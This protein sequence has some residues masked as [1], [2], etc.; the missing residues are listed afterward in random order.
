MKIINLDLDNTLIYS[1][2]HDIGSHKRNVEIYEGREVSYITERTFHSLQEVRKSYLVVPTS[3]RTVEQYNRIKLGVGKFPYALVCNGGI[4]LRNGEVDKAWYEES[5][6]IIQDSQDSMHRARIYLEKEQRRY[7]EIRYIEKL[8]VFT[9]C[10]EPEQ[11]VT[12]LRGKLDLHVVDIFNNGEKVY[13]VPCNLSKGV[14]IERLKKMLHPELVIAAGDSEFDIS[15]VEAADKGLVPYGFKEKFGVT[16]GVYEM[17]QHRVFAEALL[18]ECISNS[19]ES[20]VKVARRDNNNK[21]L[22]LVVNPLQ[23]KHI[24]V[25]PSQALSVFNQLVKQL[26]DV[27]RG[28]NVLVIG[29]AETATAIGAQVAISLGTNYIHTTR[30]TIPDV[31]Y[32][33]FSEEHSHATEQ[34]LVKNDMDRIIKNIDRILFIEDEVTTGNTILNII[35]VLENQYGQITK[36]SVASLLNGMSEEALERYREANIL[37]HYLVKTDHSTF[38]KLVDSYVCDGK[39]IDVDQTS[40]DIDVVQI[41]GC[42]NTRRLVDS[43]Q[44]LRACKGLAKKIFQQIIFSKN[45]RVLV[46]GTEECMY[47]A[48]FVG[49]Y[50]EEVGCIVKVHATTRSPIAVS[51]QDSYPVHQRYTLQSVYDEERKTFLYD[52]EQY[53]QVLIV[54]DSELQD[55]Q[56]LQTLVNALQGKNSRINVVRW[57]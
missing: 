26:G 46:V 56:G 34:K 53:D 54:T 27:Y 4:L 48:I 47:P 11:V 51:T 29:F 39:Y 13:V 9:K 33:F 35:R 38:D 16:S 25:A 18:E 28:E 31:Q 5:L 15:M 17:N 43:S 7:F 6:E 44:Y 50:L 24:P 32:L 10:K 8:F 30:E 1:Y 12:L 3:T 40:R 57:Y 2:K 49:N 20:L 14:A 52:I 37:I 21:R 42:M 23:G 36:F 22:Y 41:Q 45:E 55:R 19:K